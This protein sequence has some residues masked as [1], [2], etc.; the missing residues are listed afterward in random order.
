MT[1]N[2]P[3]ICPW[4]KTP[5]YPHVG[6]DLK[7]CGRCGKALNPPVLGFVWQMPKRKG[8]R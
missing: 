3:T 7:L 4:C 6:T 8:K 5:H 2:Q 1:P